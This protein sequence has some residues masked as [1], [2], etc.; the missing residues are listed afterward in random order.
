M[1]ESAFLKRVF[2]LGWWFCVCVCL[3]VFLNIE[4]AWQSLIIN[5]LCLA[6]W[7]LHT[8]FMSPQ[9]FGNSNS[10]FCTNEF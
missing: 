9:R 5:F 7:W 8:C 2:A 10:V 1:V 3:V 4:I 6:L